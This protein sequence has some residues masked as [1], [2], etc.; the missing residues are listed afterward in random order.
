MSIVTD[1]RCSRPPDPTGSAC[2]MNTY[3]LNGKPPKMRPVA[4]ATRRRISISRSTSAFV[5][6]YNASS[7]FV[8]PTAKART[9]CVPISNGESQSSSKSA[10]AN[11]SRR[12]R[13]GGRAVAIRQRRSGTFTE[14][15]QGRDSCPSTKKKRLVP[16]Q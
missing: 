15:S 7:N 8:R 4:A 9:R 13:T 1:A 3:R 12:P 16:F 11:V 10:A 6:P 14:T 5:R 2:T